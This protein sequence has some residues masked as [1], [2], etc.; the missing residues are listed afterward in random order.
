M[1]FTWNIQYK[2]LWEIEIQ[3]EIVKLNSKD[4]FSVPQNSKIRIST[5]NGE[6]S[7]LNCVS[8]I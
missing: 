2:G 8:Q 5:N 3:E 6:D 1:A 4:T 7:Y